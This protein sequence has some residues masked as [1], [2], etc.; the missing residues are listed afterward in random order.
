MKTICIHQLKKIE[1]HYIIILV[2]QDYLNNHSNKIF[3]TACLAAV[4]TVVSLI[5]N[6]IIFT[7]LSECTLYITVVNGLGR[8]VSSCWM[9]FLLASTKG[10]K[11]LL[12]N[13]CPC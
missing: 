11:I 10:K 8:Q 12:L 13:F 7:P 5:W 6:D 3:G 1:F 4:V 9:I 2:I